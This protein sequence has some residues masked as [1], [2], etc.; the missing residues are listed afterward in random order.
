M[1]LVTQFPPPLSMLLGT[2]ESRFQGEQMGTESRWQSPVVSTRC[3][4]CYFS[5]LNL[6]SA[7]MSTILHWCH[8]R[9][10]PNPMFLK[11]WKWKFTGHFLSPCGSCVLWGFLTACCA[12]RLQ[13]FLGAVSVSKAHITHLCNEL[14]HRTPHISASLIVHDSQKLCRQK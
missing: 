8:G 5:Q 6:N 2:K 9:N 13:C 12:E 3:F 14:Q 1:V 10:G 7:T 11:I 4:Y